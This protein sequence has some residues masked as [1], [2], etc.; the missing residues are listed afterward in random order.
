MIEHEIPAGV[1]PMAAEKYVRRAWP[2]LPGRAVRQLFAS[3]P[4]RENAGY[5]V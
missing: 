4:V 5:F 2:M 3:C 1:R